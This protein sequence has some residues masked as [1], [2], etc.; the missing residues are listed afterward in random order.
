MNDK[1]LRQRE[2]S[3]RFHLHMW[4]QLDINPKRVLKVGLVLYVRSDGRII[5]EQLRG[6]LLEGSGT[7]QEFTWR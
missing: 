2:A 3:N 7:I 1:D 5:G 4:C 6:T